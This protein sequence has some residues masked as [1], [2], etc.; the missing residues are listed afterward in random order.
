MTAPIHTADSIDTLNVLLAPET[1]AFTL[2]IPNKK[3]ADFIA[4]T[5]DVP[6]L[7]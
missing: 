5:A 4:V 6:Y 3:A 1:Q 7:F 2:A